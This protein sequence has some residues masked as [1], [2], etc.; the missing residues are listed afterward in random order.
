MN[1]NLFF[2]I[3]IPFIFMAIIS[4]GMPFYRLKVMKEAGEKKLSFIRSGKMITI[5]T[6]VIAYLLF[7]LSIMFNFG[8]LNFIIPYCAVIGLYVATKDGTFRPVNGAYENLMIIGTDILRYDDIISLPVE[9]LPPEERANHP[10]NVLV[11]VTRKHGKRQL[12]LNNANELAELLLILKEK[13]K[14]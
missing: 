5:I 13:M 6:Y 7:V 8:R 3:I 9:E 14:G 1:T 2:F 11:V 10:D 4:I 12:T